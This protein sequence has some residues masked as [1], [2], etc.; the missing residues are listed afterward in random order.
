MARP[1]NADA[2]ATKQR[3]LE[4]ATLFF[5]EKGKKSSVRDIAKGAGVSL[6][7]VHHYFGSKDDL[8]G[9]CIDAMYEELAELRGHLTEAL[10]ASSVETI[11]DD[12]VRSVFRF[13]R[14]RRTTMRLLMRRVVSR[15]ALDEGR[16]DA[17]LLPFLDQASALVAAKTGRDPASLRLPLQSL[18]FL[19]GRY[20]IAEDSELLLVTGVADAA[21]ALQAVEDHLVDHAHQMLGI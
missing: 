2:A 8:Y 21:A 13:A 14:E 17:F 20:A 6:A 11:L 15:G 1:V 16:A 7:M 9:A 18:V 12:A 4:S 3:I 10:A 19:N 5:S